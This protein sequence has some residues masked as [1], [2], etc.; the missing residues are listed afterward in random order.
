MLS[1]EMRRIRHHGRRR[2]RPHPERRSTLSNQRGCSVIERFALTGVAAQTLSIAPRGGRRRVPVPDGSSGT[3][4]LGCRAVPTGD[5]NVV[6]GAK[7]ADWIRFRLPA[8]SIEAGQPGWSGVALGRDTTA[9]RPCRATAVPS[10]SCVADD[11]FDVL[12]DH[13]RGCRRSRVSIG[14]RSAAR[15]V[16]VADWAADRCRWPIAPTTGGWDTESRNSRWPERP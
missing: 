1:P 13:L 11:D 12:A 2:L 14:R 4:R 16:V 5:V 3:I 8:R 15:S 9:S 6:R 7:F 10:V